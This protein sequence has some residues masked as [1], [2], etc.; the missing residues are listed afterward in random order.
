MY[1]VMFSGEPLSMTVVDISGIPISL[2]VLHSSG[3]KSMKG[4]FLQV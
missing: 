3:Q 1:V 4:E 2:S